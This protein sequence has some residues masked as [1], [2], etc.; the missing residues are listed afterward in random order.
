MKSDGQCPTI[1]IIDDTPANLMVLGG[2][3]EGEFDLRVATSGAEGLRL[4][5]DLR[6][7]LILLDIMMPEMDGFEVCRRL[8]AD[9]LLQGIPVIFVTA[10]SERHAE[11]AGLALGAADYIT[12]PVNVDI[13]RQRIHNLIEREALRR[14]VETNA[15]EAASQLARLKLEFMRN[16]S[17]E[18]RTPL[19]GILGLAMMGQRAGDLEKAKVSFHR[20]EVVA[21]EYLAV[22]EH[23]LDFDDAQSGRLEIVRGAFDLGLLLDDLVFQWSERAMA[24]G[25]QVMTQGLPELGSWYDGDARWINEILRQL[26]D[27]SVKFTDQG[28]VTFSVSHER[29]M[30]CFSIADSGIGMSDE[31]LYLAFHPFQQVDGSLTRRFGGVG[32][33]L[34]LVNLLVERMGGSLRVEST[35]GVGT[36]FDVRLPLAP[37]EPNMAR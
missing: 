20:I 30:M 17:H 19:N 16:M 29:E 32:L 21:T 22:V 26:L 1:L 35:P 36:R 24:K 6:P 25:L 7:Q 23:I 37:A 28:Q 15:L 2:A 12:K 14:Q 18:L 4:A 5:A 8:K 13:A 33:A 27:N 11:V 9:P 10:L 34:A 3:L 31:D